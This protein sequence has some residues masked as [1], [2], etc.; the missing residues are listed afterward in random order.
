M[1]G[2]ETWSLRAGDDFR[3]DD[4]GCLVVDA[5]VATPMITALTQHLGAW[6]ANP[7]HGSRLAALMAGEP[8]PDPAAALEDAVRT[9]LAPL[10]RARQIRDLVVRVT[11]VGNGAHITATAHDIS[12]G[13]PVT[14]ELALP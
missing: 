1:A 11:V 9:A 6:W 2:R 5:S 3:F 13:A 10:G 8:E 4:R 12:Q 14:A 7:G